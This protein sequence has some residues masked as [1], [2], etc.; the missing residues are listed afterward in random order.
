MELLHK[1]KNSTKDST[2]VMSLAMPENNHNYPEFTNLEHSDQ[3]KQITERFK[4]W[5]V[6]RFTHD[7]YTVREAQP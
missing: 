5:L 4:Y 1:Q 3:N 7:S 2:E 6:T